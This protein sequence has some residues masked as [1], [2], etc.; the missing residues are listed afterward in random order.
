MAG[1]P[2][3]G[4]PTARLGSRTHVVRASSF[5]GFASRLP[6]SCRW[7]SFREVA[8]IHARS[9]RRRRC[10]FPK[11]IRRSRAGD[12][13][14][15]ELHR[16]RRLTEARGADEIGSLHERLIGG[17]RE[18]DLPNIDPAKNT[19]SVMGPPVRGPAGTRPPHRCKRRAERSA[20]RGGRCRVWARHGT[21]HAALHRTAGGRG[22]Q[23]GPQ[24]YGGGGE[25][26]GKKFHRGSSGIPKV[27]SAFIPVQ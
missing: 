10:R 7:P 1:A 16:F 8:S 17:A 15:V 25:Q 4:S 23:A 3:R 22:A 6:R 9:R 11:C 21:A 18:R 24:H 26:T 5:F 20:R 19:S 27:A 2:P 14:D 12:H 13:E